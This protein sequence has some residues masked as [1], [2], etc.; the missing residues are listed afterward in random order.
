MVVSV[1]DYDFVKEIVPRLGAEVIYKGVNIK[2]GQHIM[3]A[4]KGNKFII[5]LPGFAYSSTVTC[6]LYAIPLIKRFLGLDSTL[7]VV[8][9]TL[10]K[11]FN[12]R[13]KK[14]E[15]T[16]CNVVFEDGKY[17]VNFDDKKVG[18]SAILTNMLDG[19]ALMITGEDDGNLD[20]GM[21][22]NILLLDTF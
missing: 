20:E 9:A 16:A 1:G 2:P 5:A 11:P 14:S 21:S 6:I 8:E 22:V 17:W 15:F 13:S 4:Q 3:V 7:N 12:K 18:T 19:A 10:K